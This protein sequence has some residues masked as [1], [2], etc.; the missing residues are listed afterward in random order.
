MDKNK[1]PKAPSRPCAT[2]ECKWHLS[3]MALERWNTGV[4]AASDDDA[5]ISIFEQ[6]GAGF[7]TEGVTVKRIAA[8]LRSIGERKV[9]V[10]INSP[11][12]DFFEGLAI[13]NLLREHRGDITVNVLGLAASAAA[14]IAMAGDTVRIARAGFLMIHNTWVLAEGDRH[15][16]RAVA[17][18]LE[19]FDASARDIF[20]SRTGLEEKE[21]GKMLD[22]ETWIGGA[23]AV[24]K[25]FADELLPADEVREDVEAKAKS[26][27]FRADKIIETALAKV[28]D[29][30]RAKRRE[31]MQAFK[32]G[33]P[34]AADDVMRNADETVL[35]ELSS[36]LKDIKR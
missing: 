20:A 28:F 2:S 11:G 16:M 15:D 31:I 10:N 19:P 26:E 36:F 35:N 18:W 7:F 34:R 8:A 22:R 5:T 1:L 24:A 25:G 30:T 29:F 14:V 17:D 9:V 4:R 13:Y 21:V 23:D 27:G 6:I 12:G 33:T 3:P 32:T